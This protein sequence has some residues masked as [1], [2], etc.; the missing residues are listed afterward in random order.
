MTK[1]PR[2]A[3]PRRLAFA[4]AASALLG[5]GAMVPAVQAADGIAQSTTVVP[6]ILAATEGMERRQERRDDRQENRGDRRDTRQDCRDEGGLVGK[7]KRDCK[8][9]GRQERR[10]GDEKESEGEEK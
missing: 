3:I 4:T 2:Y 10:E 5:L 9:E 8:Q 1:Q 6:L 7:D